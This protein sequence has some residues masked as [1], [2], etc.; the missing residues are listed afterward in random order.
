MDLTHRRTVEPLAPALLDDP[1]LSQLV[2]WGRRLADLGVSPGA[3]GNLSCRSERGFLIT[4]TGAPL[5]GIE[6]DHWVEVTGV[7]PTPDGGLQ[8]GSHGPAEPSRDSAVHA[9]TYRRRPDAACVFHLHPDYLI[10]LTNELAVP[11][12]A[13][14]HR[15]GTVES[16]REIERFLSDHQQVGYFVLVEHGIVS[17]GTTIDEAGERVEEYHRRAVGDPESLR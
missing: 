4:A 17:I 10:R 6:R 2:S 1:R 5:G 8:I 16:V 3:S 14:F 15:A 7:T 13:V 11:T 12:T 9:A